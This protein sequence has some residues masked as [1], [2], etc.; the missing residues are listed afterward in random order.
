MEKKR[1]PRTGTATDEPV[2]SI[3]FKTQAEADAWHAG[4]AEGLRR[5]R[6]GEAPG[7]VPGFDPVPLRYRRDGWT[8]DRQV[9]FI[10]AL[11][12]CGCVAEACRRIGMSAESAYELARRPDAQSFRIAW[13]IA[14]DNAVRR[15]GD[16]AFG[17]AIHGTEVPHFYKGELVGTHRRFNDRLAMFILR[18]RDPDRFGRRAETAERVHTRE[19]RAL[20]LAEVLFLVKK[21]AE[22]EEQGLPRFVSPALGAPANDDSDEDG[23]GDGAGA[24]RRRSLTSIYAFAPRI[25]IDDDEEEDD[26]EDGAEGE[27][28][29]E[30]LSDEEAGAVWSAVH[31]HLAAT[32]AAPERADEA[33]EPVPPLRHFI[34][35]A[36]E[37]LRRNT[38]SPVSGEGGARPQSGWE[39]EGTPTRTTQEPL[40][41]PDVPRT[42]STSEPPPD[43]EQGT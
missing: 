4:I 5:A 39:G 42:S 19:G 10:R 35:K 20:D 18:T 22:K 21:D 30:D 7:A 15:V 29:R 38:P 41:S 27:A 11:A 31:A 13:D 23:D 33:D 25:E 6:G 37:R 34:D 32:L 17:R 36:L 12:E 24:G 2:P 8:P 28:D 9:G 16:A 14:L 26:E 43:R 1:D 3:H 40:P